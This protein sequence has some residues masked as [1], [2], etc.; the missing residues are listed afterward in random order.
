V[1][2]CAATAREG[3]ARDRSALTDLAVREQRSGK[4]QNASA[5]DAGSSD[6]PSLGANLTGGEAT[7]LLQLSAISG[8]CLPILVKHPAGG[9]GGDANMNSCQFISCPA[10]LVHSALT[11]AQGGSGMRCKNQEL[12]RLCLRQFAPAKD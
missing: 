12:T 4:L 8:E 6:G 11:P 2:F 7:A 3:N 9:N 10:V 1:T 5:L